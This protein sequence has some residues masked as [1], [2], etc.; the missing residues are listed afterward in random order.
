MGKQYSRREVFSESARFGLLLTGIVGLPQFLAGRSASAQETTFQRIK[1]TKTVVAGFATQP[2]FAFV[3]EGKVTG[4]DPETLRA[5]TNAFGVDKVEAV[6]VDF[7]AL[8][9]G[10]I[11]KRFDVIAGTMCVRPDRCLQINFSS[12]NVIFQ[13][14]MVVKAGN[15]LNLHSYADLAH[16]ATARAATL[17]GSIEVEYLRKL[18]MPDDRILQFPDDVSALRAV[19]IDRADAWATGAPLA[20]TQLQNLKT[21]D[22]ERARPFSQPVDDKGN[23]LICYAADGFRKEDTDLLEA[24]NAELR[25]LIDSGKLLEIIRPFGFTPDDIPPANITTTQLC[26]KTG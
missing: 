21:R 11:A 7:A 23:R 25:K 10:L 3:Q 6:V 1:R 14:A 8:I 5:I 26:R 22:V 16:H 20:E 19:Q 12:P 13:E 2:P 15:P 4:Q 18:R 9:P 24:Y 17:Q